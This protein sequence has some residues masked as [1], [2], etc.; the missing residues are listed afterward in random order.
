MI[1]NIILL[2]ILGMRICVLL[3]FREFV[4]H[5]RNNEIR[6]HSPFTIHMYKLRILVFCYAISCMG[7]VRGFGSVRPSDSK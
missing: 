1:F 3:I 4:S 6:Y 7:R 5:S 2:L